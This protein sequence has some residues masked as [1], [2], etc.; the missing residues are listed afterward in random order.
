[1]SSEIAQIKQQIALE[2]LAAR[3]GL[4]GLA[5]GSA[6]HSYITARMERMGQS[7]E[8]LTYVSGSPEQ[9]AQ[10]M[11]EVLE[12]LPEQ[13]TR[14]DL[15]AV[16]RYESGHSEATEILLD[17]IRELWETIDLLRERFGVEL[18]QKIIQTPAYLSEPL[19]L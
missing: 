19:S 16:L 8:R 5:S 6:K 2:Y 9:A 12:Q 13:A 10:I 18:S 17:H 1:L 7:F 14:S 3:W 15:L 4:Y 11:A